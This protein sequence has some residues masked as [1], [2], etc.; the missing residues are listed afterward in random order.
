M[1]GWSD[2]LAPAG[3]T[4]LPSNGNAS[5]IDALL[6]NRAARAW[7]VGARVRWDLGL[8]T[9]AALQLTLEIADEE[10][11]WVRQARESLAGSPVAGWERDA[12]VVA[13][14]ALAAQRPGFDAACREGD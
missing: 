6:A 7:V 11:V 12:P 1:A 5:R 8:A 2:L 10:E 4:C 13:A 14:R 3:V 9:H